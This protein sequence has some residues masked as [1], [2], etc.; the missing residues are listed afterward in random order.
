[1]GF[2]LCALFGGELVPGIVAAS[3]AVPLL[4]SLRWPVFWLFLVAHAVSVLV[5]SLP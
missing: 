1:M 3:T 5:V 2:A 4:L